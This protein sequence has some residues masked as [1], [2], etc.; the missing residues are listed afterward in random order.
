VEVD[1]IA[2]MLIEIA[3]LHAK[4]AAALG[5]HEY[6]AAEPLYREAIERATTILDPFHT[7]YVD[8]LKGLRTCLNQQHKGDEVAKVDLM[9]AQLCLGQ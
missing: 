2:T 6:K 9:I 3:E 8:M 7:S 4:A 1:N 5:A